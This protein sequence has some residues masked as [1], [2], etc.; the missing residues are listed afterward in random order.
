ML[1]LTV[2]Y[3]AVVMPEVFLIE[4]VGG[5]RSIQNVETAICWGGLT[6]RI[7]AMIHHG[8]NH[9]WVS[10]REGKGSKITF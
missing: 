5:T 10:V 1:C 9:Y 3:L 6:Y 2:L 7:V 4:L 8:N